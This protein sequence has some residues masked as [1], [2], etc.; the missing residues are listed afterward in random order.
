MKILPIITIVC[1]I[2][3]FAAAAITPHDR[4]HHVQR[5]S[6]HPQRTLLLKM[7]NQIDHSK[8][9]AAL[10]NAG[11]ALAA[12]KIIASGNH[13]HIV[14]YTYEGVQ[15][16]SLP[17]GEELTAPPLAIGPTVYLPLRS[18]KLISLQHDDGKQQ[19]QT[20]LNSYISR[21][22]A[23][24]SGIIIAAT[25]SQHLYALDATSGK[26]LWLYDS[27]SNT[28]VVVQGAAPPL[29]IAKTV[30]YGTAAGNIVALDLHSGKQQQRWTLPRAAGRFHSI[31]GQLALP[32]SDILV[33]ATAAGLVGALDPRQP[34]NKLKWK[35]EFSALTTSVCRGDTCYV[36]LAKGEVVALDNQDGSV[37]WHKTLGWSPAFI[38]PLRGKHIYVSGSDG[39]VVKLRSTH[40]SRV[41]QENLGSSIFAPPILQRGMI[42]FSTSMRNVYAY[43]L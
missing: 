16:W 24:I 5:L 28:D 8:P 2:W 35:Q 10:N 30:Y 43:R 25:A 39:F 41:W 36:G 11:I 38:T 34:T 7:A 21:P 31:V 40:G 4:R 18:G 15:R 23:V 26:T 19:W 13:N 17:L 33:F 12:D 6:Q 3:A 1:L 14:A 27:E 9:T 20:Q 22:L 29:V 37:R 42:F 32:T